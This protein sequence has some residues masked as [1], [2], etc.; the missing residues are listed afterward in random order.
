MG[1]KESQLVFDFLGSLP[2]EKIKKEPLRALNKS[3]KKKFTL[4]LDRLNV[5]VILGIIS[6]VIVFATGVEVGKSGKFVRLS[7]GGEGSHQSGDEVATPV[8]PAQIPMP[9]RDQNIQKEDVPD[10][11]N[12]ATR[13][14]SSDSESPSKEAKMEKPKGEKAVEVSKKVPTKAS[15]G[16]GGNY[17]IQLVTHINDKVAKKEFLALGN[18]GYKPFIIQSGKYIQICVGSYPDKD[19][20]SQ[21]LKKFKTLYGDCFVRK[22]K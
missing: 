8:R 18:K 13:L 5:I 21:S 6:L 4:T 16:K 7:P 9:P 3:D 2:Q 14:A 11:S 15:S 22:S 12:A 17:T 10:T 20:A 19:N 1:Y